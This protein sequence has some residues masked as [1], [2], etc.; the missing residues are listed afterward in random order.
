MHRNYPI[1]EREQ[2]YYTLKNFK[3]QGNKMYILSRIKK[4][5]LSQQKEVVCTKKRDMQ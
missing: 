2:I 4:V 5:A 3:S 1:R